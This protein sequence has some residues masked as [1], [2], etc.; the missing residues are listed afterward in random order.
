MLQAVS[1]GSFAAM[2]S[3]PF[4]GL[5]LLSTSSPMKSA[6]DG[7]RLRL[8]LGFGEPDGFGLAP[9]LSPPPNIAMRSAMVGIVL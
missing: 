2:R 7:V 4:F 3:M 8:D 9:P 6:P 1:V 5:I